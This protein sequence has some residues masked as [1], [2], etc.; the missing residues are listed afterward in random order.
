MQSFVVLYLSNICDIIAQGDGSRLKPGKG[1]LLCMQTSKDTNPPESTS[2]FTLILFTSAALALLLII[3]IALF[4]YES[5]D[6]VHSLS[7]WVAAF[8]GMTFFEGLGA[9]V[10]NYNAPYM[11]ILNIIARIGLPD[12]YL[13]K[14]VSILF[15]IMVAYFAMKLVSL[16]TERVHLQIL[17]FILAFAIPTVVL[18]SSMWAQCDSIYAAFALGS[19]YFAYR[20]RSKTAYALIALAL[21]FKF[22]AAF[23]LPVLAVFVITGKIRFKDCYM[24][25]A[26][27]FATLLPAIIAGAPIADLL[28]VYAAQIGTY[29]YLT[30]NAINIWQ[31]VGI[32]DFSSFVTAGLFTCAL[33]ILSLLYFIYVNRERLTK[34]VDFIRLTYLFVVIAPFLL[35]KM[36]DRFFY[37]ADVLSLVVFLFD[38]R[39]WYV[40]VVTILC[41]YT[42]Y[43]WFLMEWTT[44][45]DYRLAALALMTVIIIVLR[46]FVVSLSARREG[47]HGGHKEDGSCDD[48]EDSPAD[49]E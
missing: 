3:R 27:Y 34:T 8:R 30:L 36:H 2:N 22:Q 24:L 37:M 13:I 41:S 48:Q 43:A 19:V 10:G 44:L 29:D 26:V 21:S 32:V 5:F 6:Y 35:P 16:R 39:R 25:F 14:T 11:Y 20:G 31:L 7:R 38:K 9:K 49:C 47:R 17:A 18:N 1:A 33:A 40:P 28:Q 4:E 46:D 15:D 45:F 23:M 42:V 12:L